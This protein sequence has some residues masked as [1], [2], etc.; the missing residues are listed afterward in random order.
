MQVQFL[1][2]CGLPRLAYIYTPGKGPVVIFLGGYR[3]DMT[4]TK[5]V[6]LEE[7]CKARGQGFLR[8]DYSGHGQ[9]GGTFAG[10]TIGSWKEDALAMIDTFAD[11]PVIL[12]G[13]SMGGWM[14]LLAA[15]VRP[16][17]V[18]GMVGI[19]AA[20]DFTEEIYSHLTAAQ[21]AELEKNGRVS[22]PNDYSD[23]PYEYTKAFY[24]EAKSHM[25]LNQPRTLAFPVRLI[26]GRRDKDVPWETAVKIQKN[27]ASPDFDIIFI[28]DGGHRLSRPEDLEI[29]D[30]EVRCVSEVK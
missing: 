25:V 12:V 20:P 13:S 2:R 4:G 21:K 15:L 19:A 9:S 7:Q 30:R 17:L 11:A 26:Q 6:F 5:A 28:E 1:T 10:G 24:D 8:F 3:S 14:A 23:Q 22:V 29:I 18:C 27:F 16:G